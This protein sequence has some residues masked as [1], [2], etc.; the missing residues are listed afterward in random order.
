MSSSRKADSPAASRAFRLNEEGLVEGARYVPSPNC[1]ARPPDAAIELVIV[2]A[3]SLPPG[4]FGG[5][6]IIEF[7]TNRLDF[8]AHPYYAGLADLRVSAHVLVRRDGEL[9][10]FVPC[11]RRAWHAGAS[12]WCGRSRCNDFS[13]GI[14]LEG[15]DEA[16]F[17][18]PQYDALAALSRSLRARYPI[19]DIV[20]HS[21]VAP[22]RKTDP[23]PH[24]DWPR[25]H[26]LVAQTPQQ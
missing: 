16:P 6:G 12:S 13:I 15:W 23:G 3:I 1:D 19:V 18:A 22:G 26:A 24:F 7:F 14:E 5:P 11:A 4:V 8:G 17:E 25:F 2:H 20:G 10:Q 9:I 21:D